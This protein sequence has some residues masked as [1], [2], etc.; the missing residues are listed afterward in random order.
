VF[1]VDGNIGR[2]E[3]FGGNKMVATNMILK[4]MFVRDVWQ[5]NNEAAAN[6]KSFS[7]IKPLIY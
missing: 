1:I 7:Y 6:I 4:A 5:N 2:W 3:D